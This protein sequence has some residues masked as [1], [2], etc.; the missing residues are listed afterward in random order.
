MSKLKPLGFIWAL[1]YSVLAWLGIL[2]LLLFKQADKISASKDLMFLCKIKG[3]SYVG[4]K[5]FW[6]RGFIGFTLGNGI[7][8]VESQDTNTTIKHE[9]RHGFQYFVLGIL[10]WPVYV[11]INV[12]IYLFRKDLHPYYDHPLEIDAR[13]YAGQAVKIDWDKKDR[14]SW[15]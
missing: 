14:W 8:F 6:D 15:W 12:F 2:L 5:W 13:K 10:F 3:D 1:P 11:L 9:T 4:S 7:F